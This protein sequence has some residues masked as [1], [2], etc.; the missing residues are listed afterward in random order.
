MRRAEI[1]IAAVLAGVAAYVLYDV[2]SYPGSVVPGAPGPA[3]FPRLL[4]VLLLGL[5]AMLLIRAVRRR[6]GAPSP[7]SRRGVAKNGV[8]LLLIALFWLLAERLD[9]YLLLLLL[10]GSLM[11]LMGERRARLLVS[12][13]VVFTA[14]IYFVFYRLFG[15]SFPTRLF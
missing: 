1:I 11:V 12:V 14:F 2:R 6:D 9:F 4:A 3:A 5:C 8:A 7:L 13:P 15:V 10:V